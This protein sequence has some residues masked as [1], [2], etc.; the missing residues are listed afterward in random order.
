MKQFIRSRDKEREL[1]DQ[2][3]IDRLKNLG[4][5]NKH[6]NPGE[7]GNEQVNLAD[8][9]GRR[10]VYEDAFSKIQA[11]TGITSID[12]LVQQFTAAEEKSFSL[13]TYSSQLA[14]DIDSLARQELEIKAE[15]A[16]VKRRSSE[17]ALRG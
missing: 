11:S 15:V 13:Y 3:N 14:R 7:A 4:Q 9:Q 2:R 10:Q 8:I 1:K 12:A 6:G 5:A 16:K 17:V